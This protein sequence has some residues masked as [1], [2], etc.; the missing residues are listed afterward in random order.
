MSTSPRTSEPFWLELD[1]IKPYW[2]NPRVVTDEAVNAVAESIKR[3]GYQ[4][5]IVVDDEN[6]II[7]GHTRYSAIRRLKEK[8][9]QVVRAEGLNQNQIKQLRIVDNRA[10]EYT[11]WSIDELLGE[12][13]ELDHQLMSS[14]FPEI[15]MIQEDG[16]SLDQVAAASAAAAH[17]QMWDNLETKAE[18]VCPSCFHTW[19]MEVSRDD[20]M[21]GRPLELKE[22][23]SGAA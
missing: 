13:T 15:A 17:Q 1:Q 22:E 7:I 18:F 4:Q 5:P 10:G 11:S 8:R 19:M 2:R 3:Y 9:V 23:T 21:A 20:I 16:L 6:V 14:F 12:L